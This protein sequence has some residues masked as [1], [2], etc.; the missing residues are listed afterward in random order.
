[1]WLFGVSS[2]CSS[3]QTPVPSPLP[4]LPTSTASATKTP[5]R[6]PDPAESE[7]HIWHSLTGERELALRRLA[8]SFAA[9]NPQLIRTRVEYHSDLRAEVLTAFSAGTPPDVVIASCDQ[10]AFLAEAGSVAPLA[11]Y[12]DGG[13]YGLTLT[14]QSDLWPIAIGGCLDPDSGQ[15]LGLFFD[16]QAQVMFYNASWLKKLKIESPPENWEEFRTLCNAA[17]DKKAGTWGYEFDGDGFEVSNWIA[18]LGGSLLDDASHE[19][20]L[21]SSQARAALS[22]LD[23]L[24]RDGCLAYSQEEGADRLGFGSEKILFTFDSSAE[25]ASYARAALNPRTEK[26]R[27]TWDVAPLPYGT[28]EPVVLVQGLTM[29]ILRTS[30]RQQLASW[31]FVHWFSDPENDIAWV[32]ATGALPLHRSTLEAEG[33]ASYLEQ[34]P[35][36]RTVS[37]MMAY[38]QT[39]P[40][41]AEI[42]A[43]HELLSTA[44]VAVCLGEAVPDDALLAADTAADEIHAR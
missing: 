9:T 14:Q 41:V 31:L 16:P 42:P 7:I 17:R 18:G 19:F 43:I 37:Q 40:A 12:L 34:N 15:P 1:M 20:T 11:Q 30:P 38:A 21:D 4:I 25:L 5:P 22:V 3:S 10:M 2:A 33:M 26:P 28:G 23:D 36:F 6:E 13:T 29:G 24:R 32:L 27:F 35:Q 39:D 8:A 44:A